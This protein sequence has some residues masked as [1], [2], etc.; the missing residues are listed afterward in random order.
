MQFCNHINRCISVN[1]PI[2]INSLLCILAAERYLCAIA[3]NT[4]INI[5]TLAAWP[6][7]FCA[8]H[9]W[10]GEGGWGGG[11]TL[12]SS[13]RNTPNQESS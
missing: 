11:G 1:I 13:S 12:K 5:S 8:G 9:V 2:S 10:G 6:S 7:A 3:A 4:S